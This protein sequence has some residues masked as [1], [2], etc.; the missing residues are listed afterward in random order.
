MTATTGFFSQATAPPM[1]FAR[2]LRPTGHVLVEAAL[3]FPLLI[4]LVIGIQ[5]VG[6]ATFSY[7]L[8]T[9]AVHEGARKASVK[10]SLKNG[11]RDIL[12]RIDQILSLGGLKAS[13]RSVV[14]GTDGLVRVSAQVDFVPVAPIVFQG[15]A[16]VPLRAA[17]VT[18]YEL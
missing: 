1:S 5:E 6:R 10:P 9:H 3:V 12:G 18:P 16:A 15:S 11:D 13:S 14:L 2:R 17:V 4:L 8:L 7:S